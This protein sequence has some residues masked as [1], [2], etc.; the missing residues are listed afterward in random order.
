MSSNEAY[1]LALAEKLPVYSPSWDDR[2]TNN[3]LLA[4]KSICELAK[5]VEAPKE[6]R[7]NIVGTAR[8]DI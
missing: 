7:L 4:V 1:V 5:M 3:W 2:L 6:S 8:F